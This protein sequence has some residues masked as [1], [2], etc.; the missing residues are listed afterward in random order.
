VQLAE[1]SVSEDTPLLT[2][3]LEGA[4]SELLHVDKF[5]CQLHIVIYENICIII[6][7]FLQQ[8]CHRTA[9]LYH[10]QYELL[11]LS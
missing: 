6:S 10:K 9:V 8:W 2:F 7:L 3:K 5:L 1:T 4:G 11:N